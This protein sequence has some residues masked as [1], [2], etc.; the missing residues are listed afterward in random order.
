VDLTQTTAFQLSLGADAVGVGATLNAAKVRLF[1]ND[2]LPIPA[3]VIGDFDQTTYTGHADKSIT[4]LA[5]SV[6]DDGVVEVIGTV[7]EFRPTDAV[8]PNT[9]FGALVINT[10]GTAVYMGGRFEGGPL[11]MESALDS[12]VLTVRFRPSDQSLAVV[13]S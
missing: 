4:W 3:S 10:G 1:V 12:I 11:P 13:I 9:V 5:P 7:A 2:V 6:G 8:I